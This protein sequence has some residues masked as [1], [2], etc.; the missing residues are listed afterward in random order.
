[1]GGMGVVWTATD[2]TLD[3]EV[4]I[5]VLPEAL[6]EH[7]DRLARFER[8]AKLLASLN[9]TNIA[10]V[11]GLHEGP[12][13]ERFIAMELVPGEDLAA[14]LE[15]GP[16]SVER[17]L[18]FAH[19]IAEA[20][21]AA[22]EQGV[23]HRDLKPANIVIT[24]DDRVKVLDFGLAKTLE[25]DPASGSPD[26]SMSPTLTSAGT[27]AGMMLGT[28]AY[29]SPEQ[30]RGQA[31]DKRA[32]IWGFGCLLHEM[33][34][35]TRAFPGGTVTDT[36]AAVLTLQPD[37]AT[38]PK[39]TPR[40]IRRLIERCTE[41][42]VRR[43]LRDIG[44]AR[45]AIEDAI[46]SDDEGA[47]ALEESAGAGAKRNAAP[48]LVA[49]VAGAVAV[50]AV[51][52]LALRGDTSEPRIGRFSIQFPYAAA[53]RYGD[54]RALAISPDGK[55]IV[56]SAEGG[57]DDQLY[58]RK[59]DDF[60]VRE[61]TTARSARLPVFS[62]DG[63]WIGFA[64]TEGLWKVNLAGGPPT[65]LGAF[66][67]FPLGVTWSPDGF[68]YFVSSRQLFR[69]PESG[70][71]IEQIEIEEL[72]SRTLW[73]PTAMAS[74][75][76]ILLSAGERANATL[77]AVDLEDNSVKELGL[78]GSDPRYLATGHLLFANNNQV[79]A[80]PFDADTLEVS[81]TPIPVLPRVWI[82]GFTIQA[83]FSDNGTV[84]YHPANERNSRQMVSVDREGIVEPILSGTQPFED[85]NDP[86]FSPDGSKLAVS[87]SA[88]PIWL[89]DLDSGTPTK[90]SENGFYPI[91]SPD[92][93]E[94]VYGTTRSTSFNLMQRP[95]DMSQPEKVLLDR[96]NNL[97]AGDWARDGT[98][99]FREEIPG[100]GMD[101]SHWSDR[102]DESTIETL[103]DGENDELSPSV[104]PDGRWLAY[105][106][107]QAGRD[108]I[109]VTRF[110]N[111]GG[112]VQVSVA[113]GANPL[114]SPDGRELYYF[115]G[116]KFIAVIVA[117]DPE[118]RVVSR[119]T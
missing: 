98:I 110:P 61:L 115:E 35:G 96:E 33:L 13:G 109:Y 22:H 20:L 50:G 82:D 75:K 107:D 76:A 54:G 71:E 95:I 59:I 118:F 39:D 111:P 97:R 81:G 57:S 24:P 66:S 119:M 10:A 6:A 42:D 116:R 100:K 88:G 101:L 73:S 14:I 90:L 103:L 63:Q 3:R 25:T 55:T 91:W 45:I 27:V 56:S 1:E 8:E 49:A 74:G 112:I 70:G 65:R 106:S 114:W 87:E 58:V 104:S 2:T 41:K 37:A 99:V 43:R 68:I 9:H 36:L 7:S 5:K 40:S 28:A 117:Y 113:G 93:T 19:Q 46:A 108:E 85:A 86:R 62:P 60:A 53:P 48:W 31:A 12:D 84:I 89:I 16:L 18:A 51:A 78:Q 44:E 47:L 72:R 79:F 23:I 29:M 67:A 94:L 69:V 102:S 105:A 21:E 92:G 30:A 83:A 52:W 11:Y 80:V 77:I 34:T 64:N 32:D 17:A 38:L 4:A 15:R 26:P